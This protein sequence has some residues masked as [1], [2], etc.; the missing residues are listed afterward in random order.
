MNSL[1]LSLPFALI[2]ALIP[3]LLIL[4]VPRRWCL[5]TTIILLL[6]L[7]VLTAS[8]W[9][10]PPACSSDGCIGVS[11]MQGVFTDI[12]LLCLFAALVRW[13]AGRAAALPDVADLADVADDP[14]SAP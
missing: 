6:P 3:L 5:A 7:A 2:G 9:L 13:W 8:L 11:L 1:F 14:D 4:F 10:S 12:L